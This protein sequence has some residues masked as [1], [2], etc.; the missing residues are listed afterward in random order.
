MAPGLA[1]GQRMVILTKK[2][3]E[4]GGEKGGAESSTWGLC[5]GPAQAGTEPSGKEAARSGGSSV[6]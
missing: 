1:T 3:G 2:G 4:K 5:L 6:L